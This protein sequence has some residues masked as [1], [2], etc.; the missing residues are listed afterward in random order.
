LLDN[1]RGLGLIEGCVGQ[2]YFLE[3]VRFADEGWRATFYVK[4][5]STA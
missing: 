3:L 4:G 5:A 1:W 2:D